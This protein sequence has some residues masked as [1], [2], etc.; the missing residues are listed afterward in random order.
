MATFDDDVIPANRHGWCVRAAA[1]TISP[2]TF[3]ECMAKYDGEEWAA[4]D[5]D[6]SQELDYQD[7]W[8]LKRPMEKR[9]DQRRTVADAK[10][11]QPFEIIESGESRRE[12]RRRRFSSHGSRPV[13]R[14]L[15][16]RRRSSGRTS[17][18]R[19]RVTSRGA[20]SRQRSDDGPPEPP[21]AKTGVEPDVGLRGSPRVSGALVRG[22]S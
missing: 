13:V 17:S 3:E 16:M 21:P 11:G 15:R 22:A 2:M 9:P 5:N 7:W 14:L 8:S 4:V 18:R 6:G 19:V 10:T 1:A 20:P 12:W